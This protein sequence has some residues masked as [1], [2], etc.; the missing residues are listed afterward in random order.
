MVKAKEAVAKSDSSKKL[1]PS[2][3]KSLAKHEAKKKARA[4]GTLKKKPK[5]NL[6]SGTATW[7]VVYRSGT[8]RFVHRPTEAKLIAK[9]KA[10]GKPITNSPVNIC[11]CYLVLHDDLTYSILILFYFF[12]RKIRSP[13]LSNQ[14]KVKRMV[15]LVKYTQ[16]NAR[17]TIQH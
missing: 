17:H 5:Q 1:R 2:K 12:Y 14:L 15:K 3:V 9:A 10:E 8:W 16:L 7:K 11:Y 13:S 6:L 4:A